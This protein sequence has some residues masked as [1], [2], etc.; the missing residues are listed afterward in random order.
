V[1]NVSSKPVSDY[2]LVLDGG[3]LCGPLAAQ[4]VA[5]VG[6]PAKVAP[7]PP[8]PTAAGGFEDYLPLPN[9]APRAGY[10]IELSPAP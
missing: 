10:L 6:D 1:V 7:V 5:A 2:R 9:L 4:L 3:P 8:T